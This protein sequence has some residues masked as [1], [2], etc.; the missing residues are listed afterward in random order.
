MLYTTEEWETLCSPARLIPKTGLSVIYHL[1][2]AALLVV[3]KKTEFLDGNRGK[4]CRRREAQYSKVFF[5]STLF[6]N[7]RRAS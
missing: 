1:R 7:L 4:N 5:P 6:R 3:M 2:R